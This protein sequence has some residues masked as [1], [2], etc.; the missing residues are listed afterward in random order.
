MVE[1][2]EEASRNYWSLDP[3]MEQGIVSLE[4]IPSFKIVGIVIHL[5]NPNFKTQIMEGLSFGTQMEWAI[6]K[7]KFTVVVE[8]LKIKMTK[9]FQMKEGKQIEEERI[10]FE[11]LKKVDLNFGIQKEVDL[12][13]QKEVDLNFRILKEDHTDFD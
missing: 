10:S 5:M 6:S 12:K 1:E 4:H 11:I 7:T 13:I 2:E 8:A 9:D 3:Q